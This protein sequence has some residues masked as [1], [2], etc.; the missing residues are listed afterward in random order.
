MGMH[1]GL[2]AADCDW[3]TLR[4]ALAR[5]CEEFMDIAR[6]PSEQW[7]VKPGVDDLYVGER[8]GRCYVLDPAMVLSADRDLIVAIAHESSCLVVAGGA[9]TVS[10]TF[11]FTAADGAGLRRVHFDIASALTEPFDL[12]DPLSSEGSVD[13]RDIDGAGILAR[14][15]D[16]GFSPSALINDPTFAALRV[17]WT[18]L[19]Y[20]RDRPLSAQIGEH[21]RLH[22]RTGADVWMNRI[23]VVP[24]GRGQFDIRSEPPADRRRGRFFRRRS[25]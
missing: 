11:W 6:S 15:A 19:D 14:F 25:F 22:Q 2:I 17:T 5:H 24:R 4:A 3:S 23:E 9:E 7:L 8:D 13:W 12:G 21:C 18:N 16:L 10:G 1:L 20:D